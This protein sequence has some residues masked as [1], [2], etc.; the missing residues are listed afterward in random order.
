M[1]KT[2]T[3]LLALMMLMS[4]VLAMAESAPALK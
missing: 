3:L 1:R 2:L 4:I